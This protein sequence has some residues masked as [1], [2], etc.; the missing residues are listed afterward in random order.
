MWL[1]NWSGGSDECGGGWSSIGVV[2]MVVEVSG[3]RMRWWW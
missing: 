2:E 3:W 1:V